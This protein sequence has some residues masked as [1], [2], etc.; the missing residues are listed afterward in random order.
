MLRLF[1]LGIIMLVITTGRGNAQPS[2]RVTKSVCLSTLGK[3]EQALKQ[4]LLSLA[5]RH[6]VAELFGERITSL[7]EVRNFTLTRDEIE[8]QSSGFVRIEGDPEYY[9]QGFGEGCVR[10]RAYVTAEDLARF[11]PQR[12]SKKAC[13][14]EGEIRTIQKRTETKAKLE[15]LLD[16]H[17]GLR[18]QPTERLLRL[19]H[20]VTYDE[21]GFIPNTSYYCVKA[22]GIVYPLEIESLVSSARP[23]PPSPSSDHPKSVTNSL[24]MEFVLI[25]AGRFQ[26]GTPKREVDTIVNRYNLKREWVEDESPQHD[27]TISQPFYLGKYEVTQAQWESVMGNNPSQYK[28]SDR[29]VEQVSWEEVQT[30]IEKLNARDRG[31][32][33]RLPTEAEWEYAARGSDGRRYPWGDEFD[34]TRLNFCDQNCQQE[35]KDPSANDGYATTS[36]VGRYESGRSPFGVYDMAGNVWEWVEDWYGESPSSPQRDPSGPPSGTSRVI[37][38]GSWSLGARYYRSAF[39]DCGHPGGRFVHL[40]FRLLRAVR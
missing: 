16:Y 4:Q 24:G 33:Y 18:D 22:T 36:P 12:I 11:E 34:S 19:L 25:P 17:A 27:V 7:S 30:F 14:A 32:T 5:K 13:E 26:M 20:R 6:A 35:W 21:R 15:A 2:T 31:V 23:S 40:G 8:S 3:E 9:G 37:R 1:S 39:R 38:G 29:P 10:I 28:G